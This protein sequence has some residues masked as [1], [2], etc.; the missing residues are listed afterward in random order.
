MSENFVLLEGEVTVVRKE[1][2]DDSALVELQIM[3][4]ENSVCSQGGSKNSPATI[5]VF[6]HE[7]DV[8]HI[9]EGQRVHIRGHLVSWI[10]R[11]PSVVT[12]KGVRVVGDEITLL[13]SSGLPLPS[14]TSAGSHSTPNGGMSATRLHAML[15]GNCG[16]IQPVFRE[17]AGR[18]TVWRCRVC[19]LPTASR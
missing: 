13:P 8:H 14:P 6:F 7:R 2:D 5:D 19:K 9:S 3:T 12:L 18:R 16:K 10:H 15:C 11:I 4:E 17:K 1:R